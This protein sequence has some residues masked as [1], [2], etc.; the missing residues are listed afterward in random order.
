MSNVV[1]LVIHYRAWKILEIQL[2][3]WIS[4]PQI[5]LALGQSKFNFFLFSL[6]LSRLLPIWQVRIN[7]TCLPGK[8]T[9]LWWLGG[10]FFKPCTM[11]PFYNYGVLAVNLFTSELD[12][13]SIQHCRWNVKICRIQLCHALDI[14]LLFIGSDEDDSN[15]LTSEHDVISGVL[16]EEFGPSYDVLYGPRPQTSRCIS[17]HW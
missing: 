12:T 16:R 6:D 7:G 10:T 11:A 13:A 17:F 9:C 8:F 15:L 1:L 3:L 4:S 14:L 2:G 5:S